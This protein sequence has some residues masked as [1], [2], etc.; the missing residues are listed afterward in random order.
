MHKLTLAVGSSLLLA[1]SLAQ[2]DVVGLGAS[3]GYWDSNLSGN[4][5]SGG[6]SVDDDL[7]DGPSPFHLHEVGLLC[8][9]TTPLSLNSV[10]LVPSTPSERKTAS[11]SA[12]SF[13]GARNSIGS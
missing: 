3:V 4:A 13:G 12:P 5:A 8:H 11:V 1:T 2:A 10:N 6:N 7:T 9:A